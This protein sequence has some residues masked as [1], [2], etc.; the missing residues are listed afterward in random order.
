MTH[1]SGSDES[2]VRRRVNE[3]AVAF[4]LAVVALAPLQAQERLIERT[5]ARAGAIY[6]NWSFPTAVATTA[7]NGGAELVAGVSQLTVPV[8]VVVG[9]APGWTADVYGSYVRGEV[10]LAST[11]SGSA[12][13]RSHRL[14]GLTDTKVRITGQLAG[15]AL[16][17]TAGLTL[18]TGATKLKS[19]QLDALSVLAAPGL[20]LQS[21]VIGAGAGVTAGLIFSRELG[22]WATALGGSYEA[23]STYTPAE[24]LQAGLPAGDLRPGNAVHLSLAGEHVAG[25]LRQL[26]SVT[27]DLHQHG[28]FREPFV[29]STSSSTAT[30]A[31]PASGSLGL[32]PSVSGTYEVSVTTRGTE[33]ALFVVGRR[34]GAYEVDGATVAGSARTEVDAGAQLSRALNSTTAFRLGLDGRYQATSSGAEGNANLATTA[35]TA[36]T[37]FSTAGVQ[38]VGAT[39]GLRLGGARSGTSIEPFVRG[40]VGR[41]DFRTSTST[42]TGLS[43]GAIIAARF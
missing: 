36:T 22:G 2:T 10:R 37:G 18:P 12:S 34:R 30:I 4:A 33:T 19:D 26:L 24:A 9:L 27:A 8:A 29:A 43:A 23:R 13:T 25:A 41:M 39:L 15:D 14:D 21:P 7:E 1:Q 5:T 38:A 11:A 20:R 40:Q 3:S 17:F 31:A 32:A 6:E 28:E 16:Q 42:M 35:G